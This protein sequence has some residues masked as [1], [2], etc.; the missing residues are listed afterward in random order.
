MNTRLSTAALCALLMIAAR[1]PARGADDF[2][3]PYDSEPAKEQPMPA[4]EAAASFRVPPGFRVGVFAAEPD[5][6]NP[7]AMAWDP[8]GRL[9]IA[10]NYTYAERAKK[11]DLGLRDRVLIF[12]DRDGDGH[13]DGRTVFTDGPQ[14]LTSLELGLGG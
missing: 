12:D 10:E 5:V 13:F 14:R 9:W 6:R 1:A 4:A 3:K 2:P 8:R 7:I 11:F